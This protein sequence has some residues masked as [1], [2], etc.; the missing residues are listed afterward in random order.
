[1]RDVIPGEFGDD[2][3]VII[4]NSDGQTPNARVAGIVMKACRCVF[5]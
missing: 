3:S 1:M 4:I 5:L 2:G